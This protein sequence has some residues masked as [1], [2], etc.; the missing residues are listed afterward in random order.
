MMGERHPGRI[1]VV[2]E[3]LL[4]LSHARNRGICESRGEVIAFTDDD[5]RVGSGWLRALVEACERPDVACA[6]GPVHATR[7]GPLPPG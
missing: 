1:Q 4:G 3:P 6:G 7:E 2:R 5:A